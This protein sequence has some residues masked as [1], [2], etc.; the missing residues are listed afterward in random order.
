MSLINLDAKIS[1]EYKVES[2]KGVLV[3]EVKPA[4]KAVEAGIQA[5][6]II[7]SVNQVPVKSIKTFQKIV[8]NT[9]DA[10]KDVMLLLI[11]R[12]DQQLSVVLSL[13]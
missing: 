3:A 12:K 5:G 10:N 8:L 13:R 1:K 6:D 11:K 2:Q 4:S 9:I 7:L